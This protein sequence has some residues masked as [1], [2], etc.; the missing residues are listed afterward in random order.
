MARM[1]PGELE[2]SHGS[3]GE[4]QVFEALKTLPNDYYVFHSVRWNMINERNTVEW[5]ECDFT[6]F[7]PEKGIIVIEVKSGGIEHKDGLWSYV[8]TDNG[9][10]Y[11][12]KNPLEQAS[13]SKY[14]FKDVIDDLFYNQSNNDPMFCMV[15]VAVWFPSISKKDIIGD[16]PMEYASDIVLYENALD[17]PE[18]FIEGVY[19]YYGGKRHTRL[20]LSATKD[21]IDAFAPHYQVLPSL[22]S[23]KAE[24]EA[25]FIKMTTEQN[26]L[27][28]YLEEQRVAAIQGAA[29]TGKTILA[30]EKAKRL[31]KD[32]RVLFLCFNQ[33][34]RMH[35]QNLK[36]D[37]PDEYE[38]IDFYNL[39]QYVCSKLKV[40]NVEKD[41]IVNFLERFDNYDWE[42]Q[43]IV[44]DEGQDFDHEEIDK[45]YDIA[46]LQEGAFYIFYDK[47]QFIQGMEFPKWLTNAEC[48]L[49]L[50]INCR[51]TFSIADTSGRAIN[52]EPKVKDKSIKG[53]QPIFHIVDTQK[54]LIK[55]LSALIAQCRQN[56]YSYDQICI[57]TVKTEN[58]SLLKGVEKIGVHPV[59]QVRDNSSVLFTTVRKF[60]GLE[61]DA[62][63]VVDVDED[64]FSDELSKRLFYVGASRAKHLLEIFFVGGEEELKN[65]VS[66]LE[67]APSKS[68][69]IGLAKSLNVK[70]E[71][72]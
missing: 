4:E 44:I 68:V 55:K 51:N 41:D 21:I 61:S 47:H 5:G 16:L 59:G 20:S 43:H 18:K 63:I 49:T 17:N 6:V 45:L 35:L 67:E 36:S 28:D 25:A 72:G 42:Y 66:N 71:M 7:H 46:L 50:N 8:R 48:R 62:I 69:A 39:P 10:R 11:R 70:P 12:M 57:L 34:L 38:N 29:G 54:N 53:D 3:F 22:R 24:Q 32:G 37:S 30:V 65:M 9:N 1:I 26:A 56:G 14:R 40:P 19:N 31:A 52:I 60:K 13:R 15:E 27:L 64:T 2:D 33:F 58:A 23:K